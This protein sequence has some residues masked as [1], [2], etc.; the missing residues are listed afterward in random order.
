MHAAGSREASQSRASR[1]IR[2]GKDLLGH[3]CL[4]PLLV[5]L[6][7]LCLAAIF[8][9]LPDYYTHSFPS[10]ALPEEKIFFHNPEFLNIHRE[11]IKKD[12][13]KMKESEALNAEA[14]TCLVLMRLPPLP[15]GPSTKIRMH[16]VP[17]VI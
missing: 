14:H 12:G 4:L 5:P 13:R 16:R 6:E 9:C 7:F 10:N 2:D 11:Y 17:N 3:P 15:R 1:E 8:K